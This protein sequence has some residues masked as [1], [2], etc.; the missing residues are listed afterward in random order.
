MK[1][2]LLVTAVAIAAFAGSALAQNPQPQ[3]QPDTTSSAPGKPGYS[4][5]GASNQPGS[6]GSKAMAAPSHKK[7][8][9]KHSARKGH[10]AMASSKSGHKAFAQATTKKKKHSKRM[11]AP[12][13]TTGSGA[14][15]GSYGTAPASGGG[16]QTGGQK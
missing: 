14:S 1:K 3:N 12:A 2:T 4:S 5:T 7:H 6:P 8:M 9:A 15:G 13:A 16:A 10:K 11:H